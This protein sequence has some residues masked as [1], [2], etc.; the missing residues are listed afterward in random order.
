VAQGALLG[1]RSK[2]HTAAIG[3]GFSE[4]L[5]DTN[6]MLS[7]AR[8]L[9]DVRMDVLQV[10]ERYDCLAVTLEMPFKDT[11]D[12]PDP[13]QVG[14]SGLFESGKES[15]RCSGTN[16]SPLPQHVETVDCIAGPAWSWQQT[17][18]TAM[19]TC[20]EHGNI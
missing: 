17:H 12:H 6:A 3:F 15:V 19:V 10:A 18:P 11:A 5:M 4:E 8:C 16:C 9:V 14:G 7:R 2:L 20:A 13:V 1:V